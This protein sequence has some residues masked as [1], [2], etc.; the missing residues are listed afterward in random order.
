MGIGIY[1]KYDNNGSYD[2]LKSKFAKLYINVKYCQSFKSKNTLEFDFLENSIAFVFLISQTADILI[3]VF[4]IC[5][6]I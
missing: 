1:F 6:I 2:G 3:S 4:L 5:L